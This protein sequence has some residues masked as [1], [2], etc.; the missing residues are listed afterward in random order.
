M[1]FR[2]DDD[3][4]DYIGERLTLGGETE[5]TVGGLGAGFA[6]ISPPFLGPERAV[7][8][9]KVGFIEITAMCTRCDIDG[10]VNVETD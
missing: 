8:E 7:V 4:D 1:L 6:G 3:D 10:V 5:S 9:R 2:D